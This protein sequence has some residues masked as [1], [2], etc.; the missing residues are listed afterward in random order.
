VLWRLLQDALLAEGGGL[1]GPE[2]VIVY[3]HRSDVRG[4]WDP[5]EAATVEDVSRRYTVALPTARVDRLRA[6]LRRVGNSFDQRAMHLEVGGFAE[7][8]TVQE[9]DGWLEIG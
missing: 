3:R 4:G 6:L 7:L 2:E 5:G 8:L 9:E 1:T